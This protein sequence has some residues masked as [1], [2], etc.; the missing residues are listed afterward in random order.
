M[1]ILWGQ[2][3][4][5]SLTGLGSPTYLRVHPTAGIITIYSL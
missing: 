3:C 1:L 2:G 4:T 5:W